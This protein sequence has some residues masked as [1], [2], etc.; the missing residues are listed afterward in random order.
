MPLVEELDVSSELI[1]WA[2]HSDCHE[3]LFNSLLSA[4]PSW[5]EMRSIGVGFWYSNVTQLRLKVLKKPN[6][7]THEICTFFPIS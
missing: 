7:H 3:N 6:L 1:G 2:F 5:E 4:E